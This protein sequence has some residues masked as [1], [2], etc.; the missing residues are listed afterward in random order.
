MLAGPLRPLLA[1]LAAADCARGANPLAAVDEPG[2]RAA[3]DCTR[4]AVFPVIGEALPVLFPLLLL[5]I[6][7][8]PC[9]A[10][11]CSLDPQVAGTG[12]G[13]RRGFWFRIARPTDGRT[14]S[15]PSIV[16]AVDLDETARADIAGRLR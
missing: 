9:C 2:L 8:L 3:A 6:F 16:G 7:Y 1:F 10:S 12:N 5:A 14:A 11:A 15:A 13:D 4:D